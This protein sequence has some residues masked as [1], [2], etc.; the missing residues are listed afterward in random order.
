VRGN[1][2]I[3]VIKP[4]CDPTL[5]S[6]SEA[7]VAITDN[8]GNIVYSKKH[9]GN[10]VTILGL[11]LIQGVYHVVYTQNNKRFEKSMIVQ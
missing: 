3:D 6:T 1:V 10:K 7:T 9:T 8:M 4:P 5:M 2:V 11:N